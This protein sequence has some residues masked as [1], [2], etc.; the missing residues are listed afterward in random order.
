MPEYVTVKT[1]FLSYQHVLRGL[2]RLEPDERDL[3]GEDGADHVHGGVGDV[4]PVKG[5]NELLLLTKYYY[6]L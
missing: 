1:S 5:N 3:H 2:D 4:H 6:I